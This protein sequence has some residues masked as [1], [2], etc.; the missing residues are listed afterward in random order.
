MNLKI[1][2]T[3]GGLNEGRNKGMAFGFAIRTSDTEFET[4]M[5]IS[6]CKDYLNDVVFIENGGEEFKQFGFLHKRL[7]FFKEKNYIAFRI[8][9][10]YSHNRVN[11]LNEDELERSKLLNSN[12]ENLNLFIN[13]IED[14]LNVSHS[15]IYKIEDNLFV[16]EFD[17]FWTQYGYLISCL[18]LLLRIGVDYKNEDI[19]QYFNN[20]DLNDNNGK[21]RLIE[22]FKLLLEGNLPK[23]IFTKGGEAVHNGG[24]RTIDIK[25]L[26]NEKSKENTVIPG[27]SG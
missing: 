6:T 18:S 15:I 27:I 17:K 26:I 12:F 11:P 21:A 13:K 19:I 24:F 3:R 22:N 9:N 4:V 7:N 16:I 23:Q 14:K 2:H 8:V 20:H 1:N 10:H 5:P 25:K